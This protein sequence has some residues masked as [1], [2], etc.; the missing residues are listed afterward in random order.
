ML[1]EN[2]I[3]A[4]AAAAAARVPRT[5]VAGAAENGA[6]GPF[7]TRSRRQLLDGHR[8]AVLP[9]YQPR[10]HFSARDRV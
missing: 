10:R 5:A 1:S 7:R 9:N 2:L 4:A 8:A 3:P 6:V